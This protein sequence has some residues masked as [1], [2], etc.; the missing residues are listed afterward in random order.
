MADNADTKA[1]A[2]AEKAYADAAAELKASKPAP[3]ETAAPEAVAAAPV[4]A[5]PAKVAPA[6]PAPA[7]AAPVAKAPA[8]AAPAKPVPAAAATP[9]AKP[10]AAKKKP[11]PAK[12]A[13]TAVKAP[14]KKPV[15]AKKVVAKPAAKNIPA[16]PAAKKKTTETTEHLSVKQLKDKIMATAKKTDYVE[17]V[18]EAAGKLQ[19]QLKSAYE[20]STGYASEVTEF[21]K[22][23]VEALVESGKILAAGM[24]EMGK[25]MVEETK[26]AY[27]TATEDMKKVAAVKSPT[28]FFQLQGEFARRNF[29]A[30]VSSASKS[31]EAMVKL[32]NDAF[33]PISSRVSLAVE[34]ISKAA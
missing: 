18:K 21:S 2:A 29:D 26:G 12:K 27:A 10:A 4:K 34:K 32:A 33:A 24:Q 15:V 30:A 8:K 6:K 17:T 22:G 1:D 3:T 16:K 11:A 9:A 13:P 23:N 28:E 5:T 14:A 19:E 25:D 31:T 20:K 7:K